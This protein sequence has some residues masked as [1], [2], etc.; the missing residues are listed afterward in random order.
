MADN[1]FEKIGKMVTGTGVSYFIP[2]NHQMFLRYEP[3]ETKD[4]LATLELMRVAGPH[5]PPI[6]FGDEVYDAPMEFLLV[7]FR[8]Y[9]ATFRELYQELVVFSEV[10]PNGE[11]P[12]R[13][14]PYLHCMT[15]LCEDIVA[16]LEALHL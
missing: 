8:R 3:G 5:C 15:E 2:Y 12:E 1:V 16:Q 6:T 11:L 9:R 10:F 14:I 13:D 7:D 4:D